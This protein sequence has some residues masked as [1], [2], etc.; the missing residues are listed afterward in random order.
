MTNDEARH[1]GGRPRRS[2]AAGSFVRAMQVRG[3]LVACLLGLLWAL[4]LVGA[5]WV[6][7]LMTV[8]TGRAGVQPRISITAYGNTLGFVAFTVPA[9]AAVLVFG[10]VAASGS[11]TG[12]RRRMLAKAAVT[13]SVV[14][15][16]AAVVGFATIIIGIYVLPAAVALLVG[17]NL[18]LQASGAP[19]DVTRGG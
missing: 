9:V 10:L 4:G 15:L 16:A 8:T 2:K 14:L 17:S 11:A 13:V 18:A 5:I 6:A 7:P 1:P 19:R 12:R 3:D